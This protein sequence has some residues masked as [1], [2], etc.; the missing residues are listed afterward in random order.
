MRGLKK[1]ASQTEAIVNDGTQSSITRQGRGVEEN[2]RIIDWPT[3]PYTCIE[4]LEE[5]IEVIQLARDG[6]SCRDFG[7]RSLTVLHW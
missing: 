5:V 6:I 4:P 1:I 2:S 3:R 7:V